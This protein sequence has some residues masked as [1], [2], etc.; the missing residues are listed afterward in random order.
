M[1]VIKNRRVVA[2]VVIWAAMVLSIYFLLQNELSA[3]SK[4]MPVIVAGFVLSL[5]LLVRGHQ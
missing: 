5:S 4:I 1:F 2:L 3:F